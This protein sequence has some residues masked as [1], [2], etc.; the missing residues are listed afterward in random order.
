MAKCEAKTCPFGA[1][2]G[3]CNFKDSPENLRK[4]NGNKRISPEVW[5]QI[6]KVRDHLNSGQP[7]GAALRNNQPGFEIYMCQPGKN[8]RNPQ[9]VSETQFNG[10]N[11]GQLTISVLSA[12]K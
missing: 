2:D 8:G 3:S 11:G 7:T 1:D 9:K 5:E 6:M 12:S 10:C 4:I